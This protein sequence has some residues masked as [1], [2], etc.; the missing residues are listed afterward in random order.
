[1]VQKL[2]EVLNVRE[3]EGGEP[4]AVVALDLVFDDHQEANEQVCCSKAAKTD[5]SLLADA[6]PW[7]VAD[8][9]EDGLAEVSV[10]H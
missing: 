7:R 10:D 4:A 5:E 9:K 2:K 6:D 8:T 1:V 3:L